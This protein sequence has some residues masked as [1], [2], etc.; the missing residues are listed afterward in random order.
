MQAFS[1]CSASQDYKV[2]MFRESVLTK[3]FCIN[4]LTDVDGQVAL[5][6]ELFGCV[7]SSDQDPYGT[8]VVALSPRY[9]LYM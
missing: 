3:R 2:Y 5:R 9:F 6:F 1:G 4:P 7:S 8:Y